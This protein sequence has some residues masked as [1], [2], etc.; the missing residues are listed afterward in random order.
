M[1]SKIIFGI[2][3]VC[4]L[5]FGLFTGNVCENEAAS[6]GIIGGADGP[7]AIFVTGPNLSWLVIAISV[8]IIVALAI[9]IIRKIRK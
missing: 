3:T 6:I 8:I 7:T 9:F 5:I 1:K 2:I 4:V